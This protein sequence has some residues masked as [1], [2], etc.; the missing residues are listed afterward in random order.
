MVA[1]LQNFVPVGILAIVAIGFAVMTMMASVIL[2]K[3]PTHNRIKDSPYE[4]G[5]PPITEAH[6]RFSVK[7]YVVA[8][9]FILFDIE[10][11]FLFP[12]AVV[13]KPLMK[14]YGWTIL[15]S[16]VVFLLIVEVGHAYA[17][18]KGALDW[19]KRR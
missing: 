9:L 10:L 5:M 11:V 18:R 3:K 2:G 12:W 14:E 16:V 13:F 17:W 15:W 4:C 6:P 7:F 19:G 8:M 1:E